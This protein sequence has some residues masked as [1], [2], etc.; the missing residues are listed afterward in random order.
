MAS[1]CSHQR[2]VIKRIHRSPSNVRRVNDKDVIIFM[3]INNQHVGRAV[4]GL[5]AVR[6]IRL[7]VGHPAAGLLYRRFSLA[8]SRFRRTASPV[9]RCRLRYDVVGCFTAIC[10]FTA[11][12]GDSCRFRSVNQNCLIVKCFCLT[13]SGCAVGSLHHLG[14]LP[15]FLVS[16]FPRFLVQS[17]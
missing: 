14:S 12:N 15:R 11:P 2:D 7:G 16:S 6:P 8:L 4:I 1:Q 10:L 9:A 5:V 13:I 3:T 17:V